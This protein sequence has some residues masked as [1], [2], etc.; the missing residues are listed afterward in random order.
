MNDGQNFFDQPLKN[1]LKTH[2]HIQKIAADQIDNY[3]FGSLLDY[4]YLEKY[5][6]W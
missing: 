3:T 1:D 5:L 6:K 4:P 2:D